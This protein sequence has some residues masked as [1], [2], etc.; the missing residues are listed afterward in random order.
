M[1]KKNKEKHS[2]TRKLHAKEIHNS[3]IIEEQ[4]I[5]YLHKTPIV[6]EDVDTFKELLTKFLLEIIYFNL[7]TNSQ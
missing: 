3:F 2:T 1:L 7:L 5:R 6:E 4:V